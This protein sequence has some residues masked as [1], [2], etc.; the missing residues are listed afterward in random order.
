MLISGIQKCTILDFPG[1]I[2]C[3]VFT[4][5]CNFRCG[6]CHNPE[7]VL[8]EKIMKLH[9]TF[10]PESAIFNF[11]EKRKKFLDGVVISG[12]EPT[13]MPDLIDFMGKVKQLG[14]LVKLDTNGNRPEVV[15][16][17][18][19]SGVVDYVAMDI[20]MNVARYAELVGKSVVSNNILESIELIK[21]SGVD[22]EFRS[23]LIKEIHSVS[24]LE[25]MAHLVEG[26]RRVYLQTFRPE[27]TLSPIFQTY[28]PFSGEEMQ[29]IASIFKKSSREVCVR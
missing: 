7:F 10:I 1:K 16:K 26:A 4:P 15:R 5:G 24:V 25:E 12:G 2:A 18:I 21:K 3:I 29:T 17:A 20:K 8:P 22:Y 11:F 19:T 6:Y 14:F 27:N 13:L 9:S 28:H 23:T